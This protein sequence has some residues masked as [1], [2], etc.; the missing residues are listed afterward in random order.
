M[1]LGQAKASTL[2]LSLGL[3]C[4][5]YRARHL[6]CPLLPATQYE[7]EARLTV[8]SVP[9]PSNLEMRC[10]GLKQCLRQHSNPGA[11]FTHLWSVPGSPATGHIQALLVMSALCVP[12][13]AAQQRGTFRLRL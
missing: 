8:I 9:K 3:L 7:Q 10:R 1:W 13:Q 5:R 4:G 11:A 6:S 2:E 12:R